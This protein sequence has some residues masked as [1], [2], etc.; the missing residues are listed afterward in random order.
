MIKRRTSAIQIT[1]GCCH[2]NNGPTSDGLSH[3]ASGYVALRLALPSD[4][5]TQRDV[6]LSTGPTILG[7]R[8]PA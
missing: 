7:Q 5:P 1:C 8:A 4:D 3:V 6:E 2:I